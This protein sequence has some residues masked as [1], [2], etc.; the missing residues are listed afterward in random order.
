MIE[1][2]LRRL[3][4]LREF[5]ERGTMAAVA[6][7]LGYSPSTVSQQL[8]LLEKEAG[9]RLLGRAGRGVRLTE[10]GHVLAR[11]ARVLLSAAEAAEPVMS[12]H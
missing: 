9:V 3:R 7:A 8:A 12:A 2:D 11:H 4:F 6:A 1:L 5:E 10:A